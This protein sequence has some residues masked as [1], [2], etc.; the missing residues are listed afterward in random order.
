MESQ[1]VLP[2]DNA[3]TLQSSDILSRFAFYMFRQATHGIP[4]ISEPATLLVTSHRN[5]CSLLQA[6]ILYAYGTCIF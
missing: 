2:F 6:H 1:L 5:D 3:T 4:Q